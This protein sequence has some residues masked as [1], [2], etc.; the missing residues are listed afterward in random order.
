VP[1]H[2]LEGNPTNRELELA[3]GLATTELHVWILVCQEG[4][5]SRECL[6]RFGFFSWYQKVKKPYKDAL[7][8]V[9]ALPEYATTW[10]DDNHIGSYAYGERSGR[11]VVCLSE[12]PLH[13]RIRYL[14][15]LW[16][17]ACDLEAVADMGFCPECAR[18]LPRETIDK[19]LFLAEPGRLINGRCPS[20]GWLD[21]GTRQ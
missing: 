17:D 2:D 10:P 21:K 6:G 12:K 8:D 11:L 13:K 14:A 1:H 3:H 18:L 7:V 15:S 16:E 20:C 4:A 5:L 19:E 9:Y